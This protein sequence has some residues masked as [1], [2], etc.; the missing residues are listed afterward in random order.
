MADP[1]ARR[2]DGSA[3][4]P[5]AFRAALLADPERGPA[6]AADPELKALLTGDDTDRLQGV[7]RAARSAEAS[8]AAG[9]PARVGTDAL[10]AAN[11]VPRDNRAMYAALA[12][13]GLQYGPAFR[14]LTNIHVPAAQAADA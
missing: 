11:Q 5:V 14:L 1:L 6:V 10:R 13:A 4:D 12:A 7:L 9:G 3:V 8:G 2:P